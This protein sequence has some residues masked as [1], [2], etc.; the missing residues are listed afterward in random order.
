MEK[1]YILGVQNAIASLFI[2]LSFEPIEVRLAC[3]Q[4]DGTQY[5]D[6]YRYSNLYCRAIFLKHH[7]VDGKLKDWVLIEYAD[8]LQ[9]AQT[10]CFDD[11]DMIP[12]E[13]GIDNVIAR[14]KQELFSVIGEPPQQGIL[15]Q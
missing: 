6:C 9:K 11:G 8:S 3:V 4:A 2:S 12:I 1:D 7:T 14:L 5:I 13:I 15:I 10:F